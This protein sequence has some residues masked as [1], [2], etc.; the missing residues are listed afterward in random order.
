MDLGRPVGGL[1]GVGEGLGLVVG[2]WRWVGVFMGWRHGCVVVLVT[3]PN[4]YAWP[5]III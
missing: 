5:T 1:G 2:V 4:I 3:P